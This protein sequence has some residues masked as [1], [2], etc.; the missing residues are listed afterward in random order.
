MQR[1]AKVGRISLTDACT[2]NAAH[3]E[4]GG[5][6]RDIVQDIRIFEYFLEP[7]SVTEPLIPHVQQ[8]WDILSIIIQ[9]ATRL[10]QLVVAALDLQGG[11]WPTVLSRP[12]VQAF[13]NSGLKSLRELRL[14][15]I[16]IPVDTLLLLVESCAA[17]LESIK[18]KYCALVGDDPYR[19]L[20]RSLNAMSRLQVLTFCQL[21]RRAQDDAKFHEDGYQGAS[22]LLPGEAT[23]RRTNETPNRKSTES[24]P[25]IELNI[26][27][28]VQYE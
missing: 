26:K 12:C 24:T 13:A 19:V 14:E 23:D 10:E 16:M 6:F 7:A 4:H 22:F 9:D 27:H 18:L 28:G 20:F 15:R 25:F 11:D 21:A 2:I 17:T 8:L 3:F 1:G 5:V